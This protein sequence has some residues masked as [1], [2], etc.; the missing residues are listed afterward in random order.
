MKVF[1]DVIDQ[2][3]NGSKASQDINEGEIVFIFWFCH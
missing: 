1:Y 2:Y 3:G